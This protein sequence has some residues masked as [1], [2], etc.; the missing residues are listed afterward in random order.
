MKRFHIY[1]SLVLILA[2]LIS[3]VP[4]VTSAEE[5]MVDFEE[6]LFSIS[7]EEKRIVEELF[8]QLQEI[9]G[10]ERDYA[11]INEEIET[12]KVEVKNLETYI[13]NEQD[14]YHAN[15]NV[16]E[17]ILKSYQRMGPAS[18]LEII[19]ESQNISDFLRRINVIKDLAKNTGDI[20]DSIDETKEILIQEKNKLDEKL[21]LIEDKQKALG[22]TLDNKS[23]L[24]KEQEEYLKS[25]EADRE[26]YEMY[27]NSLSDMMVKLEDLFK[28][29]AAEL[30]G[31][32]ESSNISLEELNPRLSLQGIKLTI[33][34]DLFNRIL[35]NHESLPEI[36]FEFTSAN[37]NMLIDSYN[38]KLTGSFSAY[39]GHSIEFLIQEVKFYDFLLEDKT[40]KDLIGDSILF[41]FEKILD[42]SSIKEIK[43]IDDYMELT[44]DFKLF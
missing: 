5:E 20:L 11:A 4:S 12:L 31:I 39:E 36:K 17:E 25:L 34:E 28:K 2:I 18:Y 29:L 16:L 6:K 32:I 40:V 8:V 30:P 7:E 3:T 37:V 35:G 38:I 26:H 21:S 10:L 33:N 22:Q 19:L 15:L 14:K 42:G 13:Q 44:I 41:D 23:R 27:L 24:V 1:L 43:I 9:E